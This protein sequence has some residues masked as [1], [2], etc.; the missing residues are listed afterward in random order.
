MK[1]V[2]L[3][4]RIIKKI[5][6]TLLSL[7][8]I[9]L[10]LFSSATVLPFSSPT[11]L[12][13]KISSP[14]FQAGSQIVAARRLPESAYE[15]PD[16][17]SSYSKSGLAESSDEDEKIFGVFPHEAIRR[18]SAAE[19]AASYARIEDED[20]V[21]YA[22]PNC[23]IPKFVLPCGYFL[24]IVLTSEKSIRVRYMDDSDV[25]PAREGFISPDHYYAYTETP[26]ALLYPSC[27]LTV[28]TDEVLFSDSSVT[29]PKT[30][31]PA[32]SACIFYGY[33]SVGGQSYYCVYSDGYVGYVRADAFPDQQIP[34]HPLPLSGSKDDE[35]SAPDT[36]DR[37]KETT[38]RT[39]S[40]D[41]TI[42]TVI[43]LAV[44]L[45]ALSVV[46][47]LFRPDRKRRFA[48]TEHD[49]DDLL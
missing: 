1:K 11:T 16:R 45:V 20:T 37:T 46:Y 5:C 17:K 26:P 9:C 32:S 47:L 36:S 12:A 30:V 2:F 29:V 49:R 25:F 15:K 44:S 27:K 18:V 24:K 22:D 3:S 40:I 7:A 41:S 8:A 31:L 6:D 19:P 13:A 4:R 42:K 48:F 34:D 21:F 43:V 38:P 39:T 23:T 35:A 28:K 10:I 33:L 14:L